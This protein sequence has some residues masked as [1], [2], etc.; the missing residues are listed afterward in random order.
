M[1]LTKNREAL[2]LHCLPA[3]ITGVSC[4][5]GEVSAGVFERY[6]LTTYNQAAHKPY[7]IAAMIL[8]AR[9]EQPA[10]VLAGLLNRALPRR[11]SH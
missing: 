3:D 6:R 9:F 7:V 5:A 10:K 1:S 11:L 4:E 8:L 2:Y